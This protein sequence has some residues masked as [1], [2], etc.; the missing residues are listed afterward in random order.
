[1]E[2]LFVELAKQA[3]SLLVLVL[4]VFKFLRHLSERDKA[5]RTVIEK[6]TNILGQVTALLSRL[7]GAARAPKVPYEHTGVHEN[8]V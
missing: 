2:T 8:A 7:N 6:N 5:L 4:L 1:M 3:P